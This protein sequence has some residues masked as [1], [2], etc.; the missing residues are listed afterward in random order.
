MSQSSKNRTRTEPKRAEQGSE[1]WLYRLRVLAS[2]RVSFDFGSGHPEQRRGV[3]FDVLITGGTGYMGQRLVPALLAGGHRVRVL[4]RGSSADRVPVGA[5]TVIG[6]AL[7][8]SSFERSIRQGDVLVHLVGTPHPSPAKA[9]EFRRVD[10]PSIQA[11]VAAASRSGVSH[12]IYV[13]VAHPAPMMK[14]YIEVR[15]AGEATIA[16]AGL[17]A[18]VLRP[19]YVLGPGHRWPVAL[20]PI[21]ALAE[22]LPATRPGAQRLGLVTIAQMIAALVYA[23]E[24]PPSPGI[25]RV[26]EVPEI[27]R[28]GKASG[29]R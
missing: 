6:D 9:S 14:A 12:L 28:A 16:K 19:W 18:T 3:S 21:Y 22:L 29:A 8:P 27:R 20:V 23:V 7:D 1:R 25:I 17:T 13:S 11:S 24:H 2:R 4:A 15:S 26:V 5:D 10:L